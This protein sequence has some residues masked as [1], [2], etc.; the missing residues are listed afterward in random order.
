[1]TWPAHIPLYRWCAVLACSAGAAWADASPEQPPHNALWLNLG[2]L[3]YHPNP[4]KGYNGSNPGFGLEYRVHP[5]A[6]LMAGMFTNSVRQSSRYA[7]VN[8]QPYALGNWKVG[9]AI[10]LMDGYPGIA[11]SGS[12]VAALPLASYEAT[13]FGINLGWIPTIG[14]IDGAVVLQFKLRL[15]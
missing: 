12:F 8:W 7:A 4:D 15:H 13:H 6:V 1:M 5:D 11:R 3:S 10:G 9:A 14:P 2:G